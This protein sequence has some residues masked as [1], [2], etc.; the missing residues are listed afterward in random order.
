MGAEQAQVNPCDKRADC[1]SDVANLFQH[2][3]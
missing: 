3:G 1:S 2:T